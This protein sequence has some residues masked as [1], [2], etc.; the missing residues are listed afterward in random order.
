M[1]SLGF[2]ASQ[3]RLVRRACRGSMVRLDLVV[4]QDPEVYQGS[5]ASLA[6]LVCLLM[7]NQGLLASEDPLGHV[8]NQG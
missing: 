4:N 2:Q 5:L 6:Q 3:G 1:A 7:G 8:G